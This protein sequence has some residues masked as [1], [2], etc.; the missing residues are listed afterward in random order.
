MTIESVSGVKGRD[1][2]RAKPRLVLTAWYECRTNSIY[3]IFYLYT[4]IY[5]Y[6]CKTILENHFSF[7][8]FLI[9]ILCHR[10][11]GENSLYWPGLFWSFFK[12]YISRENHEFTFVENSRISVFFVSL[13]TWKKGCQN[14]CQ[15]IFFH[16]G[17]QN[18]FFFLAAAAVLYIW[19]FLK[20]DFINNFHLYW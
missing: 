16:W 4:F 15:S 14:T 3:F 17:R 5:C 8:E 1:P 13:Q 2:T 9:I 18:Y 6:V 10:W 11:I 20:A 12:F 19:T 7:Q